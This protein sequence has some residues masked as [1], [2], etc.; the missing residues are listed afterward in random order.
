MSFFNSG[1]PLV[2]PDPD[3]DTPGPTAP[4]GTV[5]MYAGNSPFPEGWLLCAGSNILQK[6]YSDLYT[7]VGNIYSA[8]PTLG[9]THQISPDYS[10]ASNTVTLTSYSGVQANNVINVGSICSVS[11]AATPVTGVNINGLPFLVTS[12]PALGTIG[13]FNGTFINTLT[14]SG[15]GI[16]NPGD[17]A[18]LTRLTF[19]V[20]DMTGLT[21]RGVTNS[22]PYEINQ[23]GGADTVTLAAANLPAHAHKLANIGENGDGAASGGIGTV[24]DN[25]TNSPQLYSSDAIYNSS[26]TLITASGALGTSFSVLNTY[27][28]LNF[29][30]K[31]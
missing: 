29:I 10:Y 12:A 22:S 13:T 5:T 19:Q 2:V 7:V 4:T 31:T 26:N 20:P 27:I 11:G 17:V 9:L 23:K 25:A 24:D 1:Q 16:G 30:I 15:N 6:E 3:L 18:T 14:G 8:G 28:S 21:V